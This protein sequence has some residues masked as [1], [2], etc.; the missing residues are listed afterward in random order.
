MYVETVLF[1]EKGEKLM[2]SF[3]FESP[4]PDEQRRIRANGQETLRLL[5]LC[6]PL[7][8]KLACEQGI[9]TKLSSE[10][11]RMLQVYFRIQQSYEGYEYESAFEQIYKW[12]GLRHSDI[13]LLSGRV[14]TLYQEREPVLY[15]AEVIALLDQLL[16]AP[17]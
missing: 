14:M 17:E 6:I 10:D 4:L 8:T 12:A 11:E 1:F 13:G 15:E 7:A 2:S 16:H 9:Y 5:R 3:C